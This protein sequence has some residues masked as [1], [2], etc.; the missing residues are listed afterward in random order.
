M[1]LEHARPQW[2]EG[3]KPKPVLTVSDWADKKR[4]LNQ[5]SSAESGPWRTN[6]TPYLRDIMD[7][8]SD[9]TRVRE[10]TLM[11]GV[12]TGGTEAGN[13]WIAYTIDHAPG[14]FM[15]VQPTVE[16]GK[17]WS[18]QRL[19][20]MIDDMDCL[21]E[22]IKPSRSRDSGNTTLSK[23]FDG[24]LGIITG[25]NSGSG[26]RSMPAKNVMK[27]ELDAWP[28][29]VD[30]E[31][32]PSDI[33]DERTTTYSRSKILNISTPTNKA[34]SR[35]YKKFIEGDQRKYHVP[36]PHCEELQVLDLQSLVWEKDEDGEGIPETTQ[37][38]CKH[39]GALIPE[40]HKT[41]MLE[42]GKWIATGKP[43]DS[44]H[45]YHLPSYYSPL[46]WKSWADIVDKFLKAKGNREKMQV[47]TNLQDGLPFEDQTD[48]VDA[49]ILKDR[50]IPYPLG[51][52]Q[53]GDLVLTA[54]VDTQDDRFEIEVWAHSMTHSRVID[55]K[56]IWG[57]P[58][59]IST[60]KE[61]DDYLRAAWPHA[62]GTQLM[63][64]STAIDS[65][66]HKT[67]TIYDYCRTRAKERRIFAAKSYSQHWKP[68]INKPTKVD[69]SIK[70]KTIKNGAEVWMV[71]ADT[72]K[73]HIYNRLAIDNPEQEGFIYLSSQLPD[74]FF[75]GL[76]SEK[77][78][79]RY[80]KGYPVREFIKD[81]SARNEPLD[82]GMLAIAAYHRLG[83]NRW[84]PSQWEDLESTVQ[85]LT[86]DMFAQQESEDSAEQ[87]EKVIKAVKKKKRG[88]PGRSR[89]GFVSGVS[90]GM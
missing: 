39:C 33:A 40:Y 71:G 62:A 11:K 9:H 70:G 2:F 59:L 74:N 20:P 57:D 43:N 19:A 90:H 49:D 31:G 18:R 44:H 64:A 67:Q 56:V 45:S 52:C 61:L 58:D 13:N 82:C 27:D 22:K 46:G 66:G 65:G 51:E 73:K 32:D 21:N 37:A 17:R 26:L 5:R 12:Q 78:V 76:T 25:A 34:T 87:T 4:V 63:I 47:F 60:R 28:V 77:L 79:T 89:R 48:K 24:G 88:R 6:R 38:V 53:I 68:I 54:G 72:A 83:L 85:P 36:C 50:A 1:K 8:L 3:F 7:D 15:V 81:S 10:V 29:N 75:K 55:Y 41:W 80:V 42:N 16:L 30:D 86:G 14:P 35:I 84:R 23:E 69:V